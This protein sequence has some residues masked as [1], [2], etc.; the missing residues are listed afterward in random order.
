MC[1]TNPAREASRLRRGVHHA[2]HNID[3]PKLRVALHALFEDR[4]SPLGSTAS[5][6][7]KPE[8]FACLVETAFLAAALSAINPTHQG[9]AELAQEMFQNIEFL[10]KGFKMTEEDFETIQD[11]YQACLVTESLEDAAEIA[12]A[13]MKDTALEGRVKLLRHSNGSKTTT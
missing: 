9:R 7:G 8:T 13:K 4:S 10:Y 2:C 6:V 3:V 1:D 5:D 11:A 12:T